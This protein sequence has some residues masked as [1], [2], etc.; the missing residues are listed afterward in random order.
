MDFE[1]TDEQNIWRKTVREFAQKNITPKVREIDTNKKIPQ[2]IIKDMA[3]LG[4]LA[5]TVSKDYGGAEI[6][7]TMACIAAEE[8]GRAD[9]SLAIPVLY[10]VE[11]AWGFIFNR[12]G[13]SEAKT[14]YLPQ[15]TSGESFC[16]IAVTES[17]G[18]SDIVGAAKTKAEY[19]KNQWVLNGEKNFISGVTESKTWGGIHLT[20]ARTDPSKGHK[21]FSLFLVPLQDTPGVETTVFE[22]MGRMGISTGGFSMTNVELPK[23]HLVG[24]LNKG[25]YYAMEGFSAARVLIGATCIGAAE[26]AL[27]LGIDHIKTRHAFGRPIATFEGIQFPLADQ[28]CALEEI[29][30]L[31]YRAAWMMD[32]MYK[33]NMYTHH[34]VALAAAMCKLRAPIHAFTVMNEVADWLGAIGYTKEYPI[35]MGIR[36]VRSY[37]IG[38]EGTMNIMRI[39]IARELLGKE[40]LPY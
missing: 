34:D 17:E 10:L 8:L 12:Y 27:E 1:W 6:D 28:Y 32:K 37:S 24:E 30:L 36:G 15:V 19:N 29:K 35:E 21:G 38:A 13:T 14:R 9:I 16:G 26:A 18:G 3:K 39:I 11:A 4:L 2:S 22:D 20:L 23:T 33:K 40:F 25:F 31:T 5:P 7:W